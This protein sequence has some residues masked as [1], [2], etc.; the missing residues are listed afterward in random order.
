[1][2]FFVIA[3][4][5]GKFRKRKQKGKVFDISQ[6]FLGNRKALWQ[7]NLFNSVTYLF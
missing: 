1:M 3:K 5:F 4:Y 7:I 6:V 2:V